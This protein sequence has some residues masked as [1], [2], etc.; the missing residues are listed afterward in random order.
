MPV[1][2]RLFPDP[3]LTV[4]A[5]SARA[6]VIISFALRASASVRLVVQDALTHEAVRVIEQVCSVG[7]HVARLPGG[8]LSPGFYRL[9]LLTGLQTRSVSFTLLG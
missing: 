8:A 1:S 2:P 4:E 3:P 5:T 6:E 7:P 9:R